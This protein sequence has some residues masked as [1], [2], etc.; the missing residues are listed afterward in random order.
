MSFE[1]MQQD[2][3]IMLLEARTLL[4][5]TQLQVVCRALVA[6]AGDVEAHPC[7]AND[8]LEMLRALLESGP[9]G[10]RT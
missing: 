5:E 4:L 2:A 8:A 1:A 6:H 3:R 9:E 10:E 7:S